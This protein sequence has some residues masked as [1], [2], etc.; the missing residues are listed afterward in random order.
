MG[1][2]EDPLPPLLFAGKADETE[3]EEATNTFAAWLPPELRKNEL[4]L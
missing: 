3:E 1:G 2:W 4:H